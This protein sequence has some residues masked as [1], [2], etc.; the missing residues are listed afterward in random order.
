MLKLLNPFS[1][2]RTH[3]ANTIAEGSFTRFAPRHTRES[4]NQ[5]TPDRSG[6]VA[7]PVTAHRPI[8]R[9]ALVPE[10]TFNEGAH[11]HAD[12]GISIS[13]LRRALPERFAGMT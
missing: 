4:E 7:L 6:P 5:M 13:V 9:A 1:D 12:T 11:L 2:M 3:P 8:T 10:T